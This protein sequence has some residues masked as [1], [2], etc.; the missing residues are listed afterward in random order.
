MLLGD[1]NHDGTVNASDLA[2]L[3]ANW[4]HTSSGWG[5]GDFN[6]DGTVNASDLTIL[7]NW[8]KTWS[9]TLPSDIVGLPGIGSSVTPV[10]EP[11]SFILLASAA[12]ALGGQAWVRRRG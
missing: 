12:L 8:K 10:P 9:P 7:G 3:G 11:G 6:Y 5:A 1:A 2:S 4:K